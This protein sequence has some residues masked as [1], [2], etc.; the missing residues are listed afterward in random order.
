MTGTIKKLVKEKK[1]GFIRGTGGQEYFFHSS[2]LKNAR[3]DDLREGQ[4]VEFEDSEGSKGP[5]AEDIFISSN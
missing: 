5:R 3:F 1:F 2:G 4:E